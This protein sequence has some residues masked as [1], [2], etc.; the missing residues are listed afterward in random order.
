MKDSEILYK[1]KQN[2]KRKSHGL[3]FVCNEIEFAFGYYKHEAQKNSLKAWIEKMLG[4]SYTYY[5]WLS[6]NGHPDDMESIRSGQLAWL[7][8]MIAYCIEEESRG[9]VWSVE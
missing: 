7:D 1:A 5:G 2:L 9:I 3:E 6:T 8:W 4:D